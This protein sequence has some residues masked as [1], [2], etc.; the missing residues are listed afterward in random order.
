MLTLEQ[1]RREI[2][3]NAKEKIYQHDVEIA[4]VLKRLRN[5]FA[6]ACR[7]SRE[8]MEY[9]DLKKFQIE[10]CYL[11][12]ELQRGPIFFKDDVIDKIDELIKEIEELKNVSQSNEEQEQL[13][14]TDG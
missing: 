1:L 9:S 2:K 4:N 13:E 6:R 5:Q 11:V 3:E 12:D 14:Q 8:H 10:F 7:I